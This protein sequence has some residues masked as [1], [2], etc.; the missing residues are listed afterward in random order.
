[1]SDTIFGSWREMDEGQEGG[2]EGQFQEGSGV[3]MGRWERKK[4]KRWDKRGVRAPRG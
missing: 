2:Q 4:K 3:R 1:M